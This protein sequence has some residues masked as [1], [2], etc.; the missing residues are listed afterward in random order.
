MMA[1][2]NLP[3]EAA[4]ALDEAFELIDQLPPEAWNDRILRLSAQHMVAGLTSR[5]NTA[6]F[7]AGEYDDVELDCPHHLKGDDDVS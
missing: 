7:L 5:L 3:H 4:Q 2:G 1:R 6:K